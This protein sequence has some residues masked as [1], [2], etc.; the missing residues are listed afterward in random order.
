MHLKRQC[1]ASWNSCS[2]SWNNCSAL[3]NSCSWISRVVFTLTSHLE[4][5]LV[6]SF[7]ESTYLANQ[8]PTGNDV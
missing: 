1:S 7:A 8:T 5:D 4:E 6:L 2:A 3:W